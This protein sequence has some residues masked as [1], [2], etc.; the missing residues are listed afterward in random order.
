[1]AD[2]RDFSVLLVYDS[3]LTLTDEVNL[4]WRRKLSAA[5]AIFLM[6]RLSTVLI[7]IFMILQVD[8]GVRPI[9]IHPDIF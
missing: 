3:M 2:R 5:S 1:M 4:I 9:F 7:V 8:D 6:S